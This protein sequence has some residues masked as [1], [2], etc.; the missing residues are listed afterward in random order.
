MS[1]NIFLDLSLLSNIP[2]IRL[3]EMSED[4]SFL[5]EYFREQ[6]PFEV[7]PDFKDIEYEFRIRRIG[8]NTD[9]Y[10]EKTEREELLEYTIRDYVTIKGFDSLI[11]VAH[12]IYNRQKID[13]LRDRRN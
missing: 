2:E 10:N 13:E 8:L 3:R 7:Y 4:I 6:P 5:V 9:S 12:M 1:L 11:C